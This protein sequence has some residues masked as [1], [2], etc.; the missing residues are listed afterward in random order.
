MS[1]CA[2]RCTVDLVCAPGQ[3]SAQ[4]ETAVDR[5][6]PPA[7]SREEMRGREDR[8]APVGPPL[9]VS[10]PLRTRRRP[11]RPA[12]LG[13]CRAEG[14]RCGEG[15]IESR[16]WVLRSPYPLRSAHGA[17]LAGPLASAT[18]VRRGGDTGKG[19]SKS[20][21][22][23]SARRT[24]SAPHTAPAPAGDPDPRRR[25]RPPHTHHRHPDP[26]Q[27]SPQRRA[28]H[29]GNDEARPAGA[30]RAVEE[31]LRLRERR[32]TSRWPTCGSRPGSSG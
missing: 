5:R 11:R 15:R 17:V 10:P 25:P 30:G 22:G 4:V 29:P 18:A 19:G 13:D 12:R 24:P 2:E 20:A 7:C 21:R 16:P 6:R 9:A 1:S 23:S 3:R 28:T 8:I 32:P 26:L 27:P 14:R 31:V